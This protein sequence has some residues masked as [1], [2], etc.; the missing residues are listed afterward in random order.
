MPKMPHSSRKLRDRGEK[1]L[2]SM[3]VI[4]PQGSSGQENN[5]NADL[6]LRI[7]DCGIFS[8]LRIRKFVYP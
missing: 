2:L 3:I 4:L 1:Y 5:Y 7:A 6:G 8:V